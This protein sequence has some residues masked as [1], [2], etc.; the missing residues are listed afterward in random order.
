MVPWNFSFIPQLDGHRTL[1]N[2]VMNISTL[3]ALLNKYT[4]K[5]A[6]RLKIIE[7]NYGVPQRTA[8][9]V[10]SHSCIW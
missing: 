4:C 6:L 7:I 1:P 10:Y 9:I 2:Y 3:Y 8:C 5:H